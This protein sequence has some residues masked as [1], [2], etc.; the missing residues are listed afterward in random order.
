MHCHRSLL[1]ALNNA[2]VD[3][4]GSNPLLRLMWPSFR[5]HA[6]MGQAVALGLHIENIRKVPRKPHMWISVDVVMP[7]TRVETTLFKIEDMN[8]IPWRRM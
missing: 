4:A 7:V 3:D 1:T 8:L 2:Q 5:L 6:V